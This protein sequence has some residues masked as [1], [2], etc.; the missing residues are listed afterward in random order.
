LILIAELSTNHGGDVDVAEAMLHAAAEAGADYV[1]TQAY[2][3]SALNRSDPQAEWLVRSHLTDRD[4]ERLMRVAEQAGT[5]YLSTPF[6]AE[7]LKMLRGS[8]L[9]E[10]KIASSESGKDWYDMRPGEHWIRSWPW[11]AVPMAGAGC[12]EVKHT[13]LTAIPLYPTP[14]EAVGRAAM[15]D[16]WSDHC[17]GLSACEYAIAHGAKVLEVHF[18]NG[19]GRVCAWDKTPDDL[20]RLRAF[21]DDCAT[22]TSGVATKFR[23]RWSA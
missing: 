10:F 3:L 17:V 23:T 2:S 13:F 1:K 19:Q 11:G 6:D 4:H 21:A 22:I 20:K 7:A 14:L 18:T 15:L 9:R 16:G 12:G 8:G 5:R